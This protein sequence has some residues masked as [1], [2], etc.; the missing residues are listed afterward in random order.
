MD[1]TH[2]GGRL[3][4]TLIDFG[5]SRFAVWRQ[6]RLQTSTSIIE[7]LEA[8]FC[9]RGV[10]EELLIDSDT[11]FRSRSFADCG[12]MVCGSQIQVCVYSFREWDDRDA[13]E[14]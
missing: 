10:P 11:A 8:V 4:L 2:C 9:E 14:L 13:I 12:T 6:L 7:H 3:Y 1:I 5:P